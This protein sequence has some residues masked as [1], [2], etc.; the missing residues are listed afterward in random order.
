MALIQSKVKRLHDASLW[1]EPT[2]RWTQQWARTARTY[3]DDVGNTATLPGHLQGGQPHLLRSS[4]GPDTCGG[5]WP[6]HKTSSGVRLQPYRIQLRISARGRMNLGADHALLMAGVTTSSHDPGTL[7]VGSV[8][9]PGQEVSLNSNQ[10]MDVAVQVYCSNR[11][12]QSGDH[13]S[14][15]VSFDA[16]DIAFVPEMLRLVE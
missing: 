2:C 13:P 6:S 11:Q 14:S 1:M 12:V 16:S 9:L 4:S 8:F 10:S 5:L 7:F 3:H 15:A